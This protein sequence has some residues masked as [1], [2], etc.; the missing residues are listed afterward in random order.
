M[1][2]SELRLWNFR[3]YGCEGDIDFASPHLVVPFKK[4]LNIL[5]GEN[6]SGKTAILDAIKLVIKT[7]AIEWIKLDD[8]DFY[9]DSDSLRIELK[10]DDFSD[11]EASRF[12]E[13]LSWDGTSGIPFLRLIYSAQKVNGR[14]IQGDI[15]AGPTDDGKPLNSVA[16]E[17]LKCTYLKP[18]RDAASELTARKN[19]RISQ[20]LQGHE[21]FQTSQGEEHDFE[22]YIKEANQKIDRWFNDTNDETDVKGNTIKGSNHKAQLKEKIDVFLKEFVSDEME[23][24]LCISNPKI[25]NILDA[26]SVVIKEQNNLGLGTMNR[27]YMATEL[28]H[29]CDGKDGLHLC[30]IEELEAHL[31]PQ[32]QMKVISSLQK[33]SDTQFILSTH[34]P[35]LT[36]KIKLA[37]ED[38]TNFIMCHNKDVYPLNS[39]STRLK[40]EDFTFLDNFLDTTKSNLFFAKGVILVEGWA[41]ELLIPTIADKLGCNLTTNEVSIVNVGSTAYLRYAYI[42]VRTDNKILDIPV[43]VVTDLDVSPQK[44]QLEKTV[45][46]DNFDDE[47]NTDYTSIDEGAEKQKA[48]SIFKKINLPEDQK[49]K[50]FLSPHWTLEWCLFHSS[51]L[52]EAFMESVSAV[53]S[54]TAEFKKDEGGWNED[55]FK[56]KL[57]E[58]LKCRSLDKVAIAQNL[59]EKITTMPSLSIGSTDWAIYL[60]SAI[61]HASRK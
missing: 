59:C 44:F 54:K 36:S 16:R 32:A 10:F 58:K 23:S 11:I 33:K 37:N 18:L 43:S 50:L 6:D 25:K 31:H 46:D 30:L 45:G 55:S 57:I 24:E 21:L 40:K 42:F 12:T 27:L 26:I 7:H 4:G 38:K 51:A 56:G 39:S 8:S 19:S 15:S 41:E 60:V 29:L 1:F 28:L 9:D 22:T 53:H 13:W 49:V 61:K 2:L 47:D 35:N 5:V 3:K 17:Y 48:I 34:S 14:L 52:K 20:I